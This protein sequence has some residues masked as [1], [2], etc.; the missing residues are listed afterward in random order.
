ML[1]AG[2]VR[3]VAARNIYIGGA[4]RESVA[5]QLMRKEGMAK[6]PKE[7]RPE[8]KPRFYATPEE[9]EIAIA[10]YFLQAEKPTVTGLAYYLGFA[11]RMA[12][13]NYEGYSPEFHYTIK[14]AKLRIEMRY[15]ELRAST[16]AG[17]AIFALKNF[18]WKDRMDVG[19]SELP[20]IH[21]ITDCKGPKGDG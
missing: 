8:G 19:V 15:E 14:R 17:G 1:V 18:D 10:A 2:H 11:S 13:I 5:Q 9:L 21:V 6:K 16:S 20:D 4:G 7:K 3:A 12:L